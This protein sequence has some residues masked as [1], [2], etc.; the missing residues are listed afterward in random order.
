MLHVK[1]TEYRQHE[2]VILKDPVTELYTVDI[3]SD[4]FN[5]EFMQGYSDMPSEAEAEYIAKAYIDGY[6][7]GIKEAKK[8]NMLPLDQIKSE[9]QA[10]EL[11]IDWQAWQSDQALSYSEVSEWQAYFEELANKFD[12]VDEFKEN[13]II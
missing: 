7:D 6:Y 5:G 12:L 9:E 1:D 13:G 2:L 11:A 4:D 3:R 10:R 8:M